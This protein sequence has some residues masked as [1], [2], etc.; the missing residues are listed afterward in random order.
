MAEHCEHK[1][2]PIGHTFYKDKRKYHIIGYFEDY[3]NNGY[4]MFGYVCKF[5]GIHKRWWHYEAITAAEFDLDVKY[6]AIKE[7]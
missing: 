1:I 4:R 3:G 6:N 5:F 7:G 2:R